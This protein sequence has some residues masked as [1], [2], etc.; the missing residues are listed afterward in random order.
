MGAGW[1]APWV[2]ASAA[3][4][5][6]GAGSSKSVRGTLRDSESLRVPLTDLRGG[7]DCAERVD[8]AAVQGGAAMQGGQFQD[9]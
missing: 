2:G 4:G 7:S 9:Y 3:V 1:V 8:C 5:G 6:V